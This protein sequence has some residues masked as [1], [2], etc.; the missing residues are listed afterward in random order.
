MTGNRLSF[1]GFT[2]AHWLILTALGML[3][4]LVYEYMESIIHMRKY[5]K[6]RW[7]V[8]SYEVL[9]VGMCTGLCLV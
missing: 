7:I 2:W 1:S 4:M 3:L 9:D 5:N 8:V 6:L